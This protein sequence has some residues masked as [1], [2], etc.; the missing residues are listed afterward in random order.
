MGLERCWIKA[1][2]GNLLLQGRVQP[3]PCRKIDSCPIKWSRVMHWRAFEAP[4]TPRLT[5]H[6]VRAGSGSVGADH[7]GAAA[8][9]SKATADTTGLRP[10]D[11]AARWAAVRHAAGPPG[12]QNTRDAAAA[13]TVVMCWAA[14][15]VPSSRV[16]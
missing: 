3:V 16:A 7:A 2:H 12:T 9:C 4:Y 1:L 11:P 6:A 5:G 15:T 13:V 14:R 10:A 8:T